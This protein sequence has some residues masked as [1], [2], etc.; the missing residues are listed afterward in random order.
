M[1]KINTKDLQIQ[2]KRLL[3]SGNSNFYVIITR[4]VYLVKILWHKSMNDLDN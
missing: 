2:G 1:K 4:V 3:T